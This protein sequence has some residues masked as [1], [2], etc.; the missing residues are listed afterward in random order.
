M[1]D[2][3]TRWLL[4]NM[5]WSLSKKII[6]HSDLYFMVESFWLISST[7]CDIWTPNIGLISQYE[8]MFDQQINEGHC[9][10]Y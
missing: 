5:T 10:L 6:G 8:P 2:N 7:Q 4:Y 9:N 3:D 1:Y